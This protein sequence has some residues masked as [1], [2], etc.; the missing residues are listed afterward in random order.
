MT[1]QGIPD[2]IIQKIHR[3]YRLL[4]G[5][6]KQQLQTQGV[7]IG[8]TTLIC[9][10]ITLNHFCAQVHFSIERTNTDSTS[11]LREQL[12]VGEQPRCFSSI[13]QHESN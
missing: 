6:D 2:D 8:H 11:G 1:I 9:G 5:P 3:V 7:E 10:R 13:A 12:Q 4:R